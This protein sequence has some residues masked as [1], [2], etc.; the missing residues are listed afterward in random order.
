MSEEMDDRIQCKWCGRKFN[1]TAANRH[2]PLCES[3]Y[4][5]NLMK[6]GPPKAGGARG[7]SNGPVRRNKF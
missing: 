6:A 7:A 5:A 4:K 1:E 2:I 3:K